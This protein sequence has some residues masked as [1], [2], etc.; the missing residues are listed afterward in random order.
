FSQLDAYNTALAVIDSSKTEMDELDRNLSDLTEKML[1]G[2]AFKYGKDSREYEMAGGVR[3]S[4][5][6]RKSTATRLRATTEEVT[7]KDA[8]T[9]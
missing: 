8:K 3:K 7:T 9:A 4:D 1:L 6:I 5:R 2:V